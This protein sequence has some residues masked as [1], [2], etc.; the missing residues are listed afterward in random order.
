MAT[1][2]SYAKN[3][4]R[5][6]IVTLFKIG[7]T[8]EGALTDGDS[9]AIGKYYFIKSLGTSTALPA[10][11]KVGLMFYSYAATSLAVGDSVIEVSDPWD[12]MR[13]IGFANSKDLSFSKTTYDATVDYD[14]FVDTQTE[15]KVDMSGS[16]N[17]FKLINW[18]VVDSAVTESNAQFIDNIIQSPE[19]TE[20]VTRKNE[21]LLLGF[22]YSKEVPLPGATVD[23]TVV[24][25]V[26][27]GNSEGS[28]Y[29]NATT[30]NMTFTG[31]ARSADG[32]I[33]CKL[34]ITYAVA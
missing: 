9:L 24:P 10:G 26:L 29:G 2:K 8:L 13:T 22:I 31:T 20:V 14:E 34:T 25:C 28:A 16:F 30:Q 21:I 4:G 33:P 7:A 17:G 5:D 27:T 11:L 12:T 23:M 6:V 18:K 15:D 3:S 1:V 19:G 32:A